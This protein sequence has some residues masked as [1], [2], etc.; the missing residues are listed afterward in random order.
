VRIFLLTM[1]YWQNPRRLVKKHTIP[2]TAEEWAFAIEIGRA[3]EHPVNAS[4]VLRNAVT[5][6]LRGKAL[7][8]RRKKAEGT[9]QLATMP[10]SA[11]IS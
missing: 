11:K 2:I 6:Y 8:M 7:E 5:W 9:A 1:P 3:Q 10:R 4:A